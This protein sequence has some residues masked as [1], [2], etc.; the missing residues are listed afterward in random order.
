MYYLHDLIGN[1]TFNAFIHCIQDFTIN[2]GKTSGNFLPQIKKTSGKDFT[3]N[4]RKTSEHFLPHIKKQ[5][6]IFYHG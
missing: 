3:I 2:R 4:R 1:D 5:V 6:V